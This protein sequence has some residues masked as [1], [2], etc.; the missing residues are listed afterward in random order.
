MLKKKTQDRLVYPRTADNLKVYRP[1]G[2]K[3]KK[4]TLTSARAVSG[5]ISM[6]NYSIYGSV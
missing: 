6:M 1:R 4:L 2:N 5:K 3:A